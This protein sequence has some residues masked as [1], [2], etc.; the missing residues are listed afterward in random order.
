M[1]RTISHI[2][3]NGIYPNLKVEDDVAYIIDPV[4]GIARNRVNAECV[5]TLLRVNGMDGK[6]H[7][8]IIDKLLNQLIK[9][10]SPEGCWNE[11]HT[12]YDEPSA[13]ITSI[14]GEA[15]LD[16][17]VALDRKDL[18]GPIHL[19]KDFVLANYTSPG[20][21]KKSS[22]YV[23]DHLNVDATCGAFIAK[24]GKVFSDKECLEIAKKTA[25][26][27]CKYQFNDGAYP[28]TNEN[29]GNYQY[30]L[31]IPCIHY[32]GVTIYYLLKIIDALESDWLD[33]EIKKGLEWLSSVQYNDGSF[34][35]SKSG[36][37][38]AYYLSGAYAFAIPCF[39]YG[40][41]WDRNYIQSSEKAMNILDN[42][43]KDIANRWEAASMKSLPSS[44]IASIRTAAL[45]DYPLKHRAF[46]F[47]YG[48]YRQ[49][50]RRR[51]AEK[52]DP[53]L[54]N[55]LSSVMGI[56][57]STIEPDSNFP[58]LFMTSEILDCLSYSLSK[59]N[60][61]HNNTEIIL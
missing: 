34:D 47:G 22:V 3:E 29:H 18:E 6:D 51:F 43:I 50:A 15:L 31:E 38:F 42:N 26:H 11:I 48:M 20:Y 55:L 17:Y 33:T 41:K 52:V 57:T 7:T 24:Y 58:D 37:M 5:K 44:L 2:I 1:Y 61:D 40:N 56:N 60:Q 21:F 54:F 59:S 32:Q 4:Y 25:E 53:K 28:Y 45:G 27:I 46:R 14:V 49:F 8:E 19:A 23:A 16:G 30:G 39:L 13:L 10:Q 12:K 9:K 36:L 35:W